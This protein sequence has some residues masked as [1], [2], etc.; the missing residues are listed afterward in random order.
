MKTKT[1]TLLVCGVAIAFAVS[2]SAAP[3]DPNATFGFAPLGAT[4]YMPSTGDLFGATAVNIPT[5]EQ[6]NTVPCTYLANPNDF[7]NATDGCA[8]LTPVPAGTPVTF[9]TGY[10][11]DLTFLSL[12]TVTWNSG[13]DA[14]TFA[15]SNGL[16][17][18]TVVGGAESVS[19]YYTGTLT[20]SLGLYSPS[21]ASITMSFDQT[22]GPT[23]SV[24]FSGTFADPPSAA[25]GVPEPATL[26]LC[27]SA[28]IGLGLLL[29]RSRA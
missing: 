19:V 22:G 23:G 27:G 10:S 18:D 26:A 15:V 5:T 6:V 4:T 9:T 2:A 12:P 13:T 20:D 11:L 8:G 16:K 3:V 7:G 17:A 1:K 14:L 24:N 25:P 29:R 28:L 21:A